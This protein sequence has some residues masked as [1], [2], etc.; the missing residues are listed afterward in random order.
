MGVGFVD[1][2][3]SIFEMSMRLFDTFPGR[4]KE[5]VF[6]VRSSFGSK[7]AIISLF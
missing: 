2:F 3:E 7:N 5:E 6:S 4:M 1:V